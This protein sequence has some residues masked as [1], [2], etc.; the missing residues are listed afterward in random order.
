MSRLVALIDEWKD[1]HGAPSDS[2]IARSIGVKPQ[3][4][5]SWRTRGITE[6][7]NPA[8]M[9]RLA[10]FL[11]VDYEAV[12]LRAALLDA[13][14]VEESEPDTVDESTETGT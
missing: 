9:K 10:E 5:S 6:P 11:G 12:V 3:T 14:W 13:G 7:P 1:A 8:S 4:I 2:S